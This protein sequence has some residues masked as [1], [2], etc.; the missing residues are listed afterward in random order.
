MHLV[1]VPPCLPSRAHAHG[2]LP[3]FAAV[4]RNCHSM[5]RSRIFGPCRLRHRLFRRI[6]RSANLVNP[7]NTRPSLCSHP[8]TPR[9]NLRSRALTRARPIPE[10]GTIELNRSV[11]AHPSRSPVSPASPAKQTSPRGEKRRVPSDEPSPNS[12]E[13]VFPARSS[14]RNKEEGL[15]NKNE[16]EKTDKEKKKGGK[17]GKNKKEEKKKMKKI[18]KEKKRQ[19]R[20]KRKL[21]K[22]KAIAGALLLLRMPETVPDAEQKKDDG[23]TSIPAVSDVV[24][25]NTEQKDAG[26][27]PDTAVSD[28][29]VPE[30]ADYD[31]AM[32]DAGGSDD[33]DVSTLRF[34]SWSSSEPEYDDDYDDDEDLGRLTTPVSTPPS[35][36]TTK[37]KSTVQYQDCFPLDSPSDYDNVKDLATD[38]FNAKLF[39]TQPL[40]VGGQAAAAR[41]ATTADPSAAAPQSGNSNNN[42]AATLEAKMA[43]VTAAVNWHLAE[44]RERRKLRSA[45][46]DIVMVLVR[47]EIDKF[48]AR[49]D[50]QDRDMQYLTRRVRSVEERADLLEERA[51]LLEE[52]ADLLEEQWVAE[53]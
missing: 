8:H 7:L 38:T 35:S 52:R 15:N 9:A 34:E 48:A 47:E 33:S 17:K 44:Y 39:A 30:A 5:R 11:A 29:S 46:L 21:E 18:R 10:M 16:H 22:E 37:K 6:F 24:V 53:N 20:M 43:A 31:T 12:T 50:I 4:H 19:Q 25:P 32:S 40:R 28:T 45:E 41:R 1:Q 42:G 2:S 3:V 49:L 26:G 13:L 23:S 14:R 36:P 27:V 51:D